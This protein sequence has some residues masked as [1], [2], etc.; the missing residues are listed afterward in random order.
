M[1]DGIVMVDV[2]NASTSRSRKS[3]DVDI[4][5]PTMRANKTEP[6]DILIEP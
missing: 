4:P 1:M 5:R 2:N 6:A 3:H